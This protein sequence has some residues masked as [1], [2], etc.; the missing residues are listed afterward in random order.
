MTFCN[1]N[2]QWQPITDQTLYQA[3]IYYRSRPS[4]DFWGLNRT[5]ATGVPC[6]QGMLTPPDTWSRPI[7]DLH[8]FYLL[9][10]I[11]FPNL[12]LF[13]R[14]K[15]TP[16]I[17]IGV[18]VAQTEGA[19]KVFNVYFYYSLK[20]YRMWSNLVQCLVPT[21]TNVET[22][23]WSLS[24]QFCSVS[25]L[26]LR[27]NTSRWITIELLNSFAKEVIKFKII[28]QNKIAWIYKFK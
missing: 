19:C 16:K 27:S 17:V 13:F 25:M 4:T 1:D 22:V 5:F 28:I 20:R 18:T 7:G 10:L 11:L 15:A 21:D 24:R 12:S 3:W 9:R 26:R 6:R 23:K 14:C 2:I 8:M